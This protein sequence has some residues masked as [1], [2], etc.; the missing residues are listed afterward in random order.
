MNIDLLQS[1]LNSANI[2]TY[3]IIENNKAS[4]VY[5]KTTFVQDDGFRW[6]TYVPFVD[7]RAGLNIKTE[8]ELADYLY[9]LKQYFTKEAMEK[10]RKVEKNR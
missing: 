1:F 7:R 5:V 9:S 6:D 2:F 10:W 3:E 4:E 8:K